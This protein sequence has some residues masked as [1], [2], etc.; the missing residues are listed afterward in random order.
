MYTILII[1][2]PLVYEWFDA[3]IKKWLGGK[4]VVQI[5][6]GQCSSHIESFLPSDINRAMKQI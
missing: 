4:D 5:Q 3:L 1:N 2:I 6:L